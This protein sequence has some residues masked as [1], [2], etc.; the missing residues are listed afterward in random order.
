MKVISH[1]FIISLYG[2]ILPPDCS[3]KCKVLQEGGSVKAFGEILNKCKISQK[4]WA[5]V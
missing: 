2:L 4:L 5:N 1:W 3:N